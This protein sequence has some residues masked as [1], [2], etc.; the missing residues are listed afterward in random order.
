[1]TNPQKQSKQMLGLVFFSKGNG[2]RHRSST[3]AS[4]WHLLRLQSELHVAATL[5]QWSVVS[6]LLHPVDFHTLARYESDLQGLNA[7]AQSF[8]YTAWR[9]TRCM[10]TG[11][12]SP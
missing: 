2:N 6:H 9:G 8:Q 4:C 5:L 1:M 12:P 10:A 7:T 11:L 3:L